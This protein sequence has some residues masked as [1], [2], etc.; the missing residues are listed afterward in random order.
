MPQRISNLVR[1]GKLCHRSHLGWV[2]IWEP[3]EMLGNANH[4][5]LEEGRHLQRQQLTS[6]IFIFSLRWGG[7]FKKLRVQSSV[8]KV[9]V[10]RGN[11]L[12]KRQQQQWKE[13]KSWIHS[14][15]ALWE[16][17]NER[18]KICVKRFRTISYPINFLFF[19]FF[20]KVFPAPPSL[21]WL[22]VC[23]GE[24]NKFQE[25]GAGG[26]L[27]MGIVRVSV[28]LFAVLVVPEFPCHSQ[29]PALHLICGR[30][31][32]RGGRISL[33]CGCGLERGE[34][35]K[36][37]RQQRSRDVP[38]SRQ[39]KQRET[40]EIEFFWESWDPVVMLTHAWEFFKLM[41]NLCHHLCLLG[42]RGF[43]GTPR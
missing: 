14:F 4:Q 29:N 7:L 35:P 33:W 6:L 18:S 5:P 43:M 11:P 16:S 22:C 24:E 26:L 13:S 8:R 31:R 17:L 15:D 21:W 42:A 10:R 20:F 1:K 41:L 25:I 2:R 28:Q 38:E 19:F 3:L 34:W 32:G 36:E 27:V 37:A 40:W 23:L 9:V 12:E 39:S 30:G